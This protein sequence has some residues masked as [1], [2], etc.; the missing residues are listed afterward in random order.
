MARRDSVPLYKTRHAAFVDAI[1][2]ADDPDKS[3]AAHLAVG[4]GARNDTICHTH[5]SWFVYEDGSLY[6]RIPGDDPCRKYGPGI[7]G[8]CK[9][10]GHEH[11]EPKTPAGESRRILMSNEW[12][13]PATGEEEYFGLRDA[14]ESYFALDGSRAPDGV[15][16]GHEMFQGDG[17]SKG[18]LNTWI[19]EIAAESSIRPEL[20]EDRLRD[21]ITIKEGREVDQIGQFGTDSDG[22]GIPDLFAH[23]MRATYITQLMRNDVPR[24]KAIN[25]T[26]HEVPASM[27]PYVRFAEKEIDALEEQSFY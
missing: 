27:N 22:N 4:T 23:D 13:N 8:D 26:G 6:Y 17:I 1:K 7:C 25:K 20:R 21:E 14:V 11:Y 2:E 19:R 9:R 15:Q 12:T 10:L 18:T 3:T 5:S 16:Y 24:T